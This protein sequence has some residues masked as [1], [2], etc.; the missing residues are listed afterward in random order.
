M[1]R[2]QKASGADKARQTSLSGFDFAAYPMLKKPMEAIGETIGVPGNFWDKCPDA[3]KERLFKCIIKDYS[4]AHKFPVGPPCSAFEMQEMGERG[5]GSLE[6]GDSSGE[7]FWIS[8]EGRT[9]TG[10]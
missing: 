8:V 4:I 2:R 3:D 5:S 1:G 10:K 7:V 6:Q 9:V